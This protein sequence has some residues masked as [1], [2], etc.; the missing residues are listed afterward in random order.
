MIDIV[1]TK[2]D[3]LKNRIY[4]EEVRKITNEIRE[5]YDFKKE[6]EYH[7][8]FMSRIYINNPRYIPSFMDPTS[9][10]KTQRIFV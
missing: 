5:Q 6:T 4:F 8:K 3:S 7:E 9:C 1:K 10:Y 2:S